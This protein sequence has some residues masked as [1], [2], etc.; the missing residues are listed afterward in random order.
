MNTTRWTTR[1]LLQW[2]TGTFTEKDLDSPRLSAE[3]LLAH[4]IGCERLRLYMETDRPATPA[5]RD[6]LRAL[7]KRALQHEPVQYLVGEAHFFGMPF[8]V[9]RRVLIPRPSTET[10]VETLLQHARAEPGFHDALVADVC[11][12]SGCLAISIATHLPSARVVATDLSEDALDCARANA[13]RHGVED[14]IDFIRGNLLDALDQH[15]VA[16]QQGALHAL[17][18]NPPYIPD[19]EWDDVPPNVRLHEPELALRGGADGLDLVR[20]VLRDAAPR[21]RPGGILMVEVAASH[22]RDALGLVRDL[23]DA[24]IISDHEALDRVIFARR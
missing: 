13:A 2:M 15:P 17:V 12:G 18:S 8:H 3:M 11:T 4:V 7:V 20:P 6:H 19:H 1:D 23:H 5:E 22:A 24:T 21:L 16:R 14:R 9:D 10:I